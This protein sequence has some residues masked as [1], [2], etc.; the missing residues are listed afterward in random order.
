MARRRTSLVY[1]GIRNSVVAIDRASGAIAWS[2]KLKGSTSSFVNVLRDSQG[3]F[4]TCGGEI[5]C[6]DPASGTVLWHNPLKGYGMGLT[7]M[8]TDVGGSGNAATLPSEE[9][10]RRTA[11]S[12]A[13]TAATI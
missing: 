11:S 7:T 6:L 1:V 13:V 5:F 12:V 9:M 3:L 10:S 2:A 8:V 4:A